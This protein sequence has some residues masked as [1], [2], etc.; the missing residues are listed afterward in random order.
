MEATPEAGTARTQIFP[1]AYRR[2]GTASTLTCAPNSSF[3]TSDL[4][5]CETINACSVKNTIFVV[6]CYCSSRR[7]KIHVNINNIFLWKKAVFSPKISDSN[8]SDLHFSANLASSL[9]EGTLI[10]MPV[11]VFNLLWCGLWKLPPPPR[12]FMTEGEE[13]GEHLCILNEN[14]FSHTNSLEGSQ[15]LQGHW[16]QVPQHILKSDI[17]ED[18]LTWNSAFIEQWLIISLGLGVIS[19][20]TRFLQN[21]TYL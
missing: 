6:I 5:N 19:I 7:L 10:L 2:Y 17:L 18:S 16:V 12:S 20:Y 21:F 1:R 11:S 13:R 14:C 9:M 15:E 8:S 4:W 3:Q